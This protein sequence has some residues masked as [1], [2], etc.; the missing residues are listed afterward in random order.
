MLTLK[1]YCNMTFSKANAKYHVL[2]HD[3]SPPL[4]QIC[5]YT[6]FALQEVILPN[7]PESFGKI[8]EDFILFTAE[9]AMHCG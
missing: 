8:P 1:P 6:Q 9:L 7:R 5:F 2:T 4:G 3:A